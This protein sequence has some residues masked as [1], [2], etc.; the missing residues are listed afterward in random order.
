MMGPSAKAYLLVSS[1]TIA[2]ALASDDDQSGRAPA[3]LSNAAALSV[4]KHEGFA[5]PGWHHGAK[6]SDARGEE[7]FAGAKKKL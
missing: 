7:E 3:G 2:T 4:V 6:L 1:G 5:I